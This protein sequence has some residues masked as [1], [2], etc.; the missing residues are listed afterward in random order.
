MV[1]VLYAYARC[2]RAFWVFLHILSF[3]SDLG[4]YY[5]VLE[6][7]EFHSASYMDICTISRARTS[8]F[9]AF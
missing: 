3:F 2:S 8:I 5:L 1:H 9:I 4:V 6:A 7:K